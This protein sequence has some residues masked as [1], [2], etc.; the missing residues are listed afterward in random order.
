MAADYPPKPNDLDKASAEK[1]DSQRALVWLSLAILVGPS[2]VILY[3][4]QKIDDAGWPA[5]FDVMSTGW[6][7]AGASVCV[8]GIFGFLFG[9]P[10]TLQQDGAASN[11]A[12]PRTGYQANT[13]LEQISDWL[14]KILV[15]IGLTQI[16]E[17]RKAL[18]SLIKFS[19]KG[20][21]SRPS[22]ELFALALISYCALLGF[23]FGYLWARLFM[24]GALRWADQAA[25]GALVTEVQ[26]VS[27]KA[28]TTERQIED[29]KNQSTLDAQALSIAYRQLNPNP[30]L[31]D[32]SQQDLD[33]A[34]AAAS[35][36]IKVQVFNQAWEIRGDNWRDPSRKVKMERTIPVFRAL[37]KSDAENRYHSNHG[38][39]GFALKDKT[40]PDWAEAEKELTTAIEMRGPWQKAGWL[41]YEFNRALCRI[42]L[43]A[44]FSNNLPSSPEQVKA[45]LPDLNASV[46]NDELAKLVFSEPIVEKW[47]ELNKLT[48]RD[49]RRA[50]KAP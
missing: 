14:T 19:A 13:N 1:K 46:Q 17:I 18:S 8:G 16:P 45:I 41:F 12:A 42:K 10:R 40:D 11:P 15:G 6:L 31:P 21:G 23:L 36:P 47:M 2:S 49:I 33:A 38:Q 26:K 43:D 32:P 44:N 25:I 24:I 34:I 50:P 22:S 39:L 37:I 29:L 7:L 20:L 3:A 48:Q 5:F 4:F 28:E 35:R 30:N 9:I 27:E